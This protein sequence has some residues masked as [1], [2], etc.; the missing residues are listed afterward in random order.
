MRSP[1][2]FLRVGSFAAMCATCSAEDVVPERSFLSAI[3][4]FN[5]E[6]MLNPVG[7]D[8]PPLTVDE[9][10]AAIRGWVRKEHAVP[11]DYYSAFQKSADTLTLPAGARLDFT[12]GWKN[13]NGYDFVVW[14]VDLTFR[15]PSSVHS[16]SANTGSY[17]FRLRDRK[18]NC[19][20]ATSAPRT[21][22][23]NTRATRAQK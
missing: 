20:P 14:W 11:D 19:R 2:L 15:D 21:D 12:T 9:M 13:Y 5:A 10:V 23:I 22:Q 17:T 3:G 1:F 4:R 8:Q 6:A 16:D 18:V 7:K